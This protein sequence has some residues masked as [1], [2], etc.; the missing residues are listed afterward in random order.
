MLRVRDGKYQMVIRKRGHKPVS[1]TFTKKAL[2]IRWASKIEGEMESGIFQDKRKATRTTI[3]QVLDRFETEVLPTRRD[4][5]VIEGSKV[6]V[7]RRRFGTLFLTA[8]TAD[9]IEDYVDERKQ[10]NISNGT[11]VKD[12]A[13]IF[14]LYESANILWNLPCINPMIEA[15]RRFKKKKSLVQNDR[16]NR[17]LV[18]DEY[19]RL[20]TATS[21]DNAA[22]QSRLI[23]FAVETAMRREEITR[24]RWVDFNKKEQT[25]H[26]PEAK[27]GPRTIPLT[28]LAVEVLN[29]LAI[30]IDGKVWGMKKKSISRAFKRLVDRLSIKDLRFH[31]L[32]HEGCSR[33]FEAPYNLTIPEVQL[34]TGHGDWRSLQRYTQLKA[35]DVGKKLSGPIPVEKDSNVTKI[36]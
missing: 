18:D 13:V 26:I 29:S 5:G 14:D 16:R 25:L 7:I 24:M 9:M 20:T 12:L 22:T 27:Y 3:S 15:R 31:D 23:I 1:K 34:I 35:T 4:G 36:G 8:L 10:D 2:A 30:R 11:I 32:R 28:D 17:R 21:R 6:T 33:L 19:H